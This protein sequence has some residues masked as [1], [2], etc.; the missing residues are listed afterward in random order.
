MSEGAALSYVGQE[1]ELFARASRWK[2]YWASR[3]RKWVG[4]DVLEVGAGLGINTI[5]LQNKDVT[6]WLCLE[7]DSA[8]AERLAKTVAAIPNCT[9]R[10]GTTA[11][12]AERDFDCILYIDVLE[13]IEG[14]VDE[15][16]RAARLLRDGGHLIV[17]APAHPFLYSKFDAA[18]GHYRRYNKTSLRRCTPVDFGIE[19]LFYLDS[20][21]VLASLA[22]RLMLRQDTPSLRQIEVWDNFIVPGSR[23]FDRAL[24]YTIGKTVVG[25]WRRLR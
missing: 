19:S 25:V 8:L 6:S 24:G 2:S 11:N 3:I 17:L 1:L 15:M 4:G 7:P 16:A 21:G 9:V 18:I 22:N 23:F 5:A 10:S 20:L 13:H 12:V 14:D